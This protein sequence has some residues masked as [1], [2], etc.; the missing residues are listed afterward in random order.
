MYFGSVNRLVSASR[1][2][3]QPLPRAFKRSGQ[4]QGPDELHQLLALWHNR[5]RSLVT[6]RQHLV[7]EAES[8]LCELPLDLSEQL[9]DTKAVKQRLT[10][11]IRRNRRRRYDPPTRLRLQLLDGYHQQI[12]ALDREEKQVIAHLEELVRRSGSTLGELI[13]MA[14]LGITI[15]VLL[16]LSRLD[17]R[18]QAVTQPA[19]QLPHRREVNL[20]AQL[21]QSAGEMP[22]AL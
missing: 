9:P 2:F 6:T 17:V 5:R 18:L 20:V 8:L 19:Q 12:H 22:N 7:G 3:I 10:A 14:K 21:P 16:A 15:W 1:I 13:D 4:E 11:L